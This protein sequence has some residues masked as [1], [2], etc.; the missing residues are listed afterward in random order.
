MGGIGC[1]HCENF[2]HD[3][4]AWTF[5][6]IAPVQP[7]LHRVSCS[8]EMVP[9]AAKH[10]ETQQRMSLG[11]QWGGLGAFVVKTFD[12]TLWH[13]LLDSLHQFSPF[14]TEF[15]ALTKW[16]KMHPNTMKRT[17]TWV[18]D[19]MRADRVDLLQKF[20]TQLCGLN[21]CINY[22]SSARIDPSIVKQQ[23]GPKCSQTL[24]NKTK[25]EFRFQWGGSGAFVVKKS[26]TTSW[27]ELLH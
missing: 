26:Y 9:N 23:N 20:L 14:C 21:F 25:H 16:S 11:V 22:N 4:V 19:Q 27:H 2:G 18:Y 15:H 5:A 3:F 24:R 12:A 7:I 17:K 1:I 8:N 13:L 6:L 10:Y